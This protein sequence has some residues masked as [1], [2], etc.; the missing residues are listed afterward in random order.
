MARLLIQDARFSGGRERPMEAEAQRGDGQEPSPT[1]ITR[2]AWP[3][4]G[5][6]RVV[7]V[8][9]N[10]DTRVMLSDTLHYC[11]AVV[12]AYQSAEAVIADLTEVR[13]NVLIC[14]LSMPGIDGLE[15]MRRVRALPPERGGRVPAIA[16]TAYYEDF[17]AAVALEVGFDAYVT[18]PIKLEGLCK[19]VKE[20]AATRA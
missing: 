17:A 6:I 9:D 16:I 7:L 10:S 2:Y 8:E 20:L 5:D 1:R 13:P 18:K 19:L 11:G 12:T 15:F 3:D 4:L 14:D